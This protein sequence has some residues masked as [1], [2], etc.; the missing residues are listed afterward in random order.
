[1]KILIIVNE[2]PPEKIRG[3]AMATEALAQSLT[4]RGWHV[5][6]IVTC[7][8]S[9]PEREV[10]QGIKLYR[11]RP[12]PI[13]YTRTIQRF[14]KILRLAL[15][16]RPDIIQGQAASCGLFAAIVGKILRA[17]SVTYMQGHDLYESGPIRLHIE[18][19][20][21][22]KYATKTI[23]ATD[24]LARGVKPYAGENVDVIPYGYQPENITVQAM[25]TVKKRMRKEV[26]NILF[27]GYLHTDKGAAYLISAVSLLRVRLPGIFLHLV[28]DGPLRNELELYVKRE[29]VSENVCFYGSLSHMEVLAMMRTVDLFVLPSIEEP[30]GIVLIEALNQGCPV[31]ATRIRAIPT[32]IEDGITGTLV[33]P[34]D[35]EAIARA[36]YSILTDNSLRMKMKQSARITAKK[37]HWDFNVKRFEK[38]YEEILKWDKI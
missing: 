20:P 1:M 24:E 38:V 25:E 6:V 14:F 5:Y 27:V 4:K 3:T 29:G 30:F 19:W 35:P 34:R 15:Q 23:A 11:L 8:D 13:P 17:P 32:I 18:I 31:V 16:I 28:G 21:S 7:R 36:V 37:F 26:P 2:Y 33:S 22:V 9:A 10:A 12:W